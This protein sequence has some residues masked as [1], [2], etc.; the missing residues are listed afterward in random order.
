MSR[1]TAAPR[2]APPG[3]FPPAPG[4]YHALRSQTRSAGLTAAGFPAAL[5]WLRG[6][7]HPNTATPNRQPPARRTALALM[8]SALALLAAPAAHAQSGC[9][10]DADWCATMTVGTDGGTDVINYGFV[11]TTIV[12]KSY[13]SLSDTTIEYGNRSWSINQVLVNIGSGIRRLTIA[14]DTALPRGTIITVDG[15]ALDTHNANNDVP[16]I[17]NWEIPPGTFNW[18]V[19]QQVPISVRLGN[20]GSSGKPNISGTLL[21]HHVLSADRGN[22]SDPD[23]TTRADRGEPGYTY[24]YQWE[25][26]DNGVVSEIAGA[27]ER[28]YT[29]RYDDIGNAIRV[30]VRFA[31]DRDNA[32]GPRTSEQTLPIQS[33]GTNAPPWFQGGG[34]SIE[35]M[36]NTAPGTQIGDPFEATDAPGDTVTYSLDEAGEALVDID[37]TTGQVTLRTALDYETKRQHVFH[38]H[39]TDHRGA[40]P[41]NGPPSS[42]ETSRSPRSHPRRRPSPWSKATM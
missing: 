35:V 7:G 33:D 39:A 41:N 22:I 28:T 21:E 1:V 30:M 36:E 20:L 31:D 6:L 23:G 15:Q 5:S 40:R 27:I 16:H 32:E 2:G 34:A 10:V 4:G 13:G 19:G 8:L 29:L 3:P 11:D 26:I 18:T 37:P 14:T 17:P 42:Y 12:F 9:P 25:Q 24:T 38:V